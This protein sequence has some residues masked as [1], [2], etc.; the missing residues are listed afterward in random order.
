MEN[1]QD[2]NVSYRIHERSISKLRTV[3]VGHGNAEPPSRRVPGMDN[4]CHWA[5]NK[6]ARLVSTRSELNRAQA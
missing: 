2:L 3:P 6:R 1:N 5:L 4:H